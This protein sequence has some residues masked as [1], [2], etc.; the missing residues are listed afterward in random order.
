MLCFMLTIPKH[1][2]YLTASFFCFP[3]VIPGKTQSVLTG[4]LRS[5]AL[6]ARQGHGHSASSR[7]FGFISNREQKTG[8]K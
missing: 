3:F 8:Q 5:A 7:T 6:G 2:N 4:P 1:Q